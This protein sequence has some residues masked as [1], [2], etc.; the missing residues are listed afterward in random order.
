MKKLSFYFIFIFLMKN[1]YSQIKN[2]TLLLK[3]ID[4]IDFKLDRISNRIDSFKIIQKV[5]TDSINILLSRFNEF[6]NLIISKDRLI[7]KNKIEIDQKNL[8]LQNKISEN[9]QFLKQEESIIA[10]LQDEHYNFNPKILEILSS[11]S[12]IL[13]SI[14]NKDILSKFKTISSQLAEVKQYV[15]N[16]PFDLLQNNRFVDALSNLKK[17]AEKFNQLKEDL[18]F[19]T[20]LL[21]GYSNATNEVLKT[22]KETAGKQTLR[23]SELFRVEKIN[24]QNYIYLRQEID[25]AKKDLNY[26][27]QGQ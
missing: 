21:N 1:G 2:D 26:K 25:K 22:I 15:D 24:A 16:N 3:K 20:S 14:N 19:F 4:Q 23:Y 5:K 6:E 17:Y 18:I 7:E 9:I 12:I 8:E 13:Y 10:A 27:G 11:N